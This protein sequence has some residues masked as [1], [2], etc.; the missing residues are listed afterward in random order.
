MK[1][2]VNQES[3]AVVQKVK[4]EEGLEVEAEGTVIVVLGPGPGLARALV[5]PVQEAD[6]VEVIVMV[7]LQ[8]AEVTVEEDPDT[9]MIEEV[10]VAEVLLGLKMMSKFFFTH[11]EH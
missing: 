3:A 6:T 9:M 2:R 10:A 7:V 11:T 8:N 5:V 4:K 1:N